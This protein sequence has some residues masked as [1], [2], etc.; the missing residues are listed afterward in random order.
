[1]AGAAEWLGK[2]LRLMEGL[3]LH[4]NDRFRRLCEILMSR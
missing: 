2:L 4:G 1:M 3:E